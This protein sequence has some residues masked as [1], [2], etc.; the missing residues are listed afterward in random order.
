MLVGWYWRSLCNVI[1]VA[2]DCM[3]G[4]GQEGDGEP[5]ALEQE[6]DGAPGGAAWQS[7][8]RGNG[9]PLALAC[10][11]WA[12][13]LPAAGLL[14]GLAKPCC[15]VWKVQSDDW[16]VLDST[17]RGGKQALIYLSPEVIV[18]VA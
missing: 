5:L 18:N 2:A 7:C 9:T 14:G 11:E 4:E 10:R 6:W 12:S 8:R 17:D 13:G 15:S 1:I 16:G 3:V